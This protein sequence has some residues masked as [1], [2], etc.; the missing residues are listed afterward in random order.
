LSKKQKIGFGLVQVYTGDGKGKTTAALG[1]ALRAIGWGFQVYFIQ[2]LKGKSTLKEGA[3]K[4]LKKNFNFKHKAFGA[5]AF[6]IKKPSRKDYEEA[7]KAL[8]F[9]RKVIMSKEYDLV[10]LDEITHAINL[11]LIAIEDV[12][13]LIKN[14]P[15]NVE[16]ILTGRNAP[17]ELL[18]IADLVTEMK[19]V[20]H[21]FEKGIYARKGIEY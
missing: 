1:I 11:K 8:A 13:D 20:K 19:M 10:V 9:S 6:I 21:P 18:E 12:L 17:K 2:F 7:K 5:G 16:L 14:K 4:A 15:K 3:F